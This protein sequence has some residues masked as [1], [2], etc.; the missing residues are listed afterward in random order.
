MY[1]APADIE[2]PRSRALIVA[3]VGLVGCAAGFL[4]DRDHFFRAW[5]IAYM[6]FLGIAVGSLALMMIQHLSGGAWGIFRRIFEAS[7]RTLPLLAMLFVPV[8]LGMGY[9]YPWTHA[10]LVAQDHILQYK[11]PYLN[12]TFFIVRAVLYFAGWSMLSMVLNRLSLRQDAGDASVNL[13][14]QRLSG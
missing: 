7:S 11:A 5:L 2:V 9:L 13:P 1:S 12:S 4:I 8:L 10:D 14:L 3:A 6:L